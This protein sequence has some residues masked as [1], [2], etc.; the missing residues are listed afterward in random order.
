MGTSSSQL[1]GK[2]S[3]NLI[4]IDA[5]INKGENIY[6]VDVFRKIYS[7]SLKLFEKN[8]I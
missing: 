2:N 3:F 7:L 8:K 4:W 5:N 1:K 6:Y